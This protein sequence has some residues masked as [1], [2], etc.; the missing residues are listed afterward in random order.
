MEILWL[1]SVYCSECQS[2]GTVL[3]GKVLSRRIHGTNNSM[4]SLDSNS[5]AVAMS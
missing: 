1:L 4:S 5:K 3:T 2:P